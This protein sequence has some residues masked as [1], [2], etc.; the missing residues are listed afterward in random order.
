MH[1]DCLIFQGVK[2]WCGEGQ[3]DACPVWQIIV[4]LVLCAF[5]ITLPWLLFSNQLQPWLTARSSSSV[6]PTRTYTQTQS[7]LMWSSGRFTR[8]W[9][10]WKRSQQ[11]GAGV[12]CRL[13]LLWHWTGVLAQGGEF[14]DCCPAS[15]PQFVE[16]AF[17]SRVLA[18]VVQC[19]RKW[20][21]FTITSALEGWGYAYCVLQQSVKHFPEFDGICSSS[22]NQIVSKP[23]DQFSGSLV[24]VM[25]FGAR[26]LIWFEYDCG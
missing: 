14:A 13:T 3:M 26:Q 11:G 9:R 25:A 20:C 18:M 15:C 1:T 23:F 22:C 8:S 19:F 2:A 5:R 4:G 21:F 6:S 24:M 16:W 17:L 10:D 7:T 12:N